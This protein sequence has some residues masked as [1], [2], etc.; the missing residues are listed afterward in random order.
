MIE[1][2]YDD[3]DAAFG[4]SVAGLCASKLARPVGETTAWSDDWWRALA[5]LV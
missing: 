5:E 3:V 1:L 2:N 4:A